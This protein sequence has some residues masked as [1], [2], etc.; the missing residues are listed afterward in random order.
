MDQRAHRSRSALQGDAALPPNPR[1][2][3]MWPHKTLQRVWSRALDAAELPHVTLYE[4]TKHTMA[5]DALRS[6]PNE[7]EH[8][9]WA[10]LDSNQGEWEEGVAISTSCGGGSGLATSR[11]QRGHLDARSMAIAVAIPG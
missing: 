6:H 4:G 1:P 3:R 11:R 9:G 10:R 7:I 2:G 5:T 8:S